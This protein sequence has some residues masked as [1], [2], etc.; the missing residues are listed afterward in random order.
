MGYEEAIGF[1]ADD[2]LARASNINNWL[3]GGF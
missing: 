2:V 1:K 3:L